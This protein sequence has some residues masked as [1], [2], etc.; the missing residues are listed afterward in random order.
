MR[1][2][3][4]ALMAALTIFCGTTLFGAESLLK[5]K[6][7]SWIQ[8]DFRKAGSEVKINSDNS[9][10]VKVKIPEGKKGL[11]NIQLIKNVNLAKDKKYKLTFD[12]SSDVAGDISA[13][14]ILS[15]APWTT[16]ASAK[17]K[18]TSDKKTYECVIAPKE[19]KDGYGEPR[20]LR[21]Y[22]ANLNGA[23]INISNI[24]LTEME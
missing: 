16:Y 9:I 17:I 19:S 4:T 14:Y 6:W 15:K 18:V 7:G 8:G 20:S 3:H 12:L 13:S 22:L 10:D 24:S 11:H 5:G 1:M 23:T 21:F 2:K